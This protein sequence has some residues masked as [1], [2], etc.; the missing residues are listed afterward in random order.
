VDSIDPK[1]RGAFEAMVL[2]P[3]FAPFEQNLG[4]VGS[5]VFESVLTDLLERGR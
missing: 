1:I 3:M 2:A 5:T 4:P